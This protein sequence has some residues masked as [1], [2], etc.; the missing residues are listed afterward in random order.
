MTCRREYIWGGG[1][2]AYPFTSPSIFFS[3]FFRKIEP[4]PAFQKIP[5]LI[6]RSVIYANQIHVFRRGNINKISTLFNVLDRGIL[7]FKKCNFNKTVY[8]ESK[9]LKCKLTGM[10][11]KDVKRLTT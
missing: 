2:E 7:Y 4:N 3:S 1:P 8:I 11:L 10:E 6:F 5:A 9:V